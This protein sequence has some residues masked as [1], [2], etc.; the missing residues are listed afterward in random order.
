MKK[1][2]KI[3]LIVLLCIAFAIA[4]AVLFSSIWLSREWG[5]LSTDEVIYHIRAPLSG[6]NPDVIRNYILKYLLPALLVTAATVVGFVFTFKNPLSSKRFAIATAGLLVVSWGATCFILENK[7]HVISYINSQLHPTDYIETHYVDP[8]QVQM[9]FPEQKRNLIYIYIES[10]EV[11]YA[12]KKNGGAFNQNT[13][14]ELTKIAQE[15]EDFSGDSNELNGGLSLDGSVWTM[16]AMFAQTSGLPLKLSIGG[17][18]M[19]TQDSFFPGVMTLGDILED[20]G[21]VNELMIGSEA[22]FGGRELYFATHGNYKMFDYNYA[23]ENGYIDEDYYV[24][25]GFED[26]KLFEFA[27]EELLELA[28]GDAPFNLTMLT[29]DTHA[30]DGYVCQN[31]RK[32][33]GNNQYAN[34]FACSSRQVSEFVSWCQQQD[35]YENTTIILVGDH[36]TMDSDFCKKLPNGYQRKVYTAVINSAVEPA[37]PHRTRVFSTM[38]LFPTTLAALGVEIPGDRLGLGTNLFSLRDTY[39]ETYG[40]ANHNSGLAN[41]SEFIEMLD[42]SELNTELQEKLLNSVIVDQT[43]ELREDGVFVKIKMWTEISLT[44]FDKADLVVKYNGMTFREKIAFNSKSNYFFA[45]TTIPYSPMDTDMLINIEL[46]SGDS[47]MILYHD[48]FDPMLLTEDFLTYLERLKNQDY[49]IF[50]AAMDDM[51]V[52]LSDEDMQKL[53]ELGITCDLKNGYRNSYYAILQGDRLIAE[54]MEDGAALRSKGDLGGI[55]YIISSAGFAQGNYASIVL[56][57]VEYS[58]M[59]RGLNIVVYDMTEGKVVSI[60]NFDTNDPENPRL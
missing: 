39:C 45:K 22:R 46:R 10:A 58:P 43:V 8:R 29:V 53:S 11:T 49:L 35:F 23:K 41:R 38:D 31:C 54:R 15:N 17:N 50:I 6:S 25:W 16:G 48:K 19:D 24:W 44:S 57:G 51:S 27:K 34:V 32:E 60:A 4:V 52:G 28:K 2:K 12:D 14:P 21:Y 55:E 33:F 36:P 3:V 30:E 47:E 13:I 1:S 18:E 20:N 37:D 59:G 26:E 7:L 56:D 5:N 40:P 9:E 42:A